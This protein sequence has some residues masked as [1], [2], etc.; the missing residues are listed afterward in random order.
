MHYSVNNCAKNFYTVY[1]SIQ[2]PFLIS[3]KVI[4]WDILQYT[5]ERMRTQS[6]H[7]CCF[8]KSTYLS[9]N[10][11][12]AGQA[13]S[14]S[15]VFR[16]RGF[17][18]NITKN[19]TKPQPKQITHISTIQ[20]CIRIWHMI[21]GFPNMVIVLKLSNINTVP[22]D[23]KFYYGICWMEALMWVLARS[24]M[25]NLQ[26]NN[27]DVPLLTST[28]QTTYK[29]FLAMHLRYVYLINSLQV[30]ERKYA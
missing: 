14:G 4:N 22:Y 15:A 24:D 26:A 27:Y 5:Q 17:A 7:S 9:N 23:E 10:S 18:P 19:G 12:Q 25:N 29:K 21:F 3:Q 20:I 11:V 8:S 6:T 13:E 2:C 16:L 30:V 1:D 28:G